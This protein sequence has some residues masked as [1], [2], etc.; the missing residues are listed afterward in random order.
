MRRP[1]LSRLLLSLPL[2][3]IDLVLAQSPFQPVNIPSLDL[4]SFGQVSLGGDFQGISLYQYTAQNPSTQTGQGNGV[5]I[6][7]PNGALGLLGRA[8]GTVSSLCALDSGIYVGG[9]FSSIAGV[10]A[11]NIAAYNFTTNVFEKLNDREILGSVY[12]LYCNRTSNQ[13]YVGG[14]FQSGGSNNAIVWDQNAGHWNDL[15]FGG[16]DGPINSI[17]P[18]S[19][20]NIL[21]GGVFDA[22]GNGSSAR[23]SDRQVINL[24]SANV[25]PRKVRVDSRLQVQVPERQRASQIHPSYFVITAQMQQDQPGS[26][27]T[28]PPA[29]SQSSVASA[30]VQPNS[31]SATPTSLAAALKHSGS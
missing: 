6:Q 21:F 10:N 31:V 12:A 16:F 11:S 3:L 5:Y 19:N 9:N 1:K 22:L 18:G 30:T 20:G 28:T 27:R 15:P 26:Y 25:S 13:V 17:Q 23:A 4:S 14:N 2:A 7:L 29:T 8:Q 24:V